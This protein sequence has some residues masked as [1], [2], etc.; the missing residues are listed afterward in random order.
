MCTF[1]RFG[2]WMLV[3][4]LVL[5]VHAPRAPQ[6]AVGDQHV[7]LVRLEADVELIDAHVVL[8]AGGDLAAPLVHRK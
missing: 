8:L 2:C 4:M 6:L 1:L 5:R 3:L 7:A